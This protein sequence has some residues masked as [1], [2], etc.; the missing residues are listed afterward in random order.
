MFLGLVIYSATLFVGLLVHFIV[1]I[2]RLVQTD[3]AFYMKQE[4]RAYNRT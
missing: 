1:L 3:P 2:G 4:L